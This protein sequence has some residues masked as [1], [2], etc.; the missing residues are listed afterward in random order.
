MS[1]FSF[2]Y[3][4][5]AVCQMNSGMYFTCQYIDLHKSYLGLDLA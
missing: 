5:Y 2:L 3:E 4:L 1:G